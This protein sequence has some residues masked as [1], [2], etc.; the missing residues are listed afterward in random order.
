MGKVINVLDLG[1]GD[2]EV[3]S[4]KNTIAYKIGKIINEGDIAN[5]LASNYDVNVKGPKEVPEPKK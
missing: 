3:V 1:S 5:L 4:T 2:Y